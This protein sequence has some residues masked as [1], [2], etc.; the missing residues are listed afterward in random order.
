[1][2]AAHEGETSI[3]KGVWRKEKQEGLGFERGIR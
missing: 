3:E 1:M 2:S